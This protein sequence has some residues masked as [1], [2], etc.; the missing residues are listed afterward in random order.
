MPVPPGLPIFVD[1]I[2]RRL[3]HD[4]LTHCLGSLW[5]PS[6]SVRLVLVLGLVEDLSSVYSSSIM[7]KG[8]FELF[9][10]EVLVPISLC[11]P[12]IWGFSS[13]TFVPIFFPVHVLFSRW[14]TDDTNVGAFSLSH[15]PLSVCSLMSGTDP[16]YWLS[17]QLTHRSL[18]SPTC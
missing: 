17:F 1:E 12:Q 3:N 4:F 6:F 5:L 13:R 10:L 14:D 16:S 9:F 15:R 2:F 11:M 8:F 7:V 18:S